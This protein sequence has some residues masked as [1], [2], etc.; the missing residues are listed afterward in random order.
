VVDRIV[1]ARAAGVAAPAVTLGGIALA[2]ARSP[3]FAWGRSALSDLGRAGAPTAPL[4][5]AA[6]VC[7][8]A[9]GVVFA[10][11]LRP[12]RVAAGYAAASL[13]LA[14][15][16]LFP[17]GTPLHVPCA[18]GF[19][20]A[21]TATL[22]LAAADADGRRAAATGLAALAVPGAWVAWAVLGRG[23]VAVPETVGA[24]VVGAWTAARAAAG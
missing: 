17:A 13:S 5:A 8:G 2:V 21:A 4:F 18:V 15:V 22:A 7:G 23:G 20:A 24:V 9:L 14:G 12:R 19:F 1:L 10:A 3:T 6:L 16:G 11:G